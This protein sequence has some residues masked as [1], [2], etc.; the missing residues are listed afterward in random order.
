MPRLFS[1][2]LRENIL[3]GLDEQKVDLTEALRL[4]VLEDDVAGLDKGL[5]TLVG[6]RGIRLSGGQIQRA[7]AARMFVREPELLR[8][9]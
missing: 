7:A 1:D 6:P 4:S 3:L 8:L 2:P 5:D 9:R